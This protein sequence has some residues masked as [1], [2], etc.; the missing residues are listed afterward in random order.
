MPKMLHGTDGKTRTGHPVET[1]TLHRILMSC[2]VHQLLFQNVLLQTN[3]LRYMGNQKSQKCCRWSVAVLSHAAG[4]V[5][6][7]VHG[8]MTELKMLDLCSAKT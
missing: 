1:F 7:D 4:R 6:C 3:L 8:W 5:E 2:A